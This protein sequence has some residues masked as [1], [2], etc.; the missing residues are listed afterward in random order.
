MDANRSRDAWRTF[1]EEQRSLVHDLPA[2]VEGLGSLT[3]PTVVVAGTRDRVVPFAVARRLHAELPS[4][5]LIAVE[6]GRHDLHRSHP[7]A[8]AEAVHQLLAANPRR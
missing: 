2:V 3:T 6:G 8:I 5:E 4:A 7:R 1:L